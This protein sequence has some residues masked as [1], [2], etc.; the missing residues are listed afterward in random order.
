[1]FLRT[2]P[3]PSKQFF[4]LNWDEMHL[5]LRN[6]NLGF[7]EAMA[8]LCISLGTGSSHSVSKYSANFIEK[9]IGID[10]RK[11][12][13]A[14][15]NLLSYGH[16]KNESKN[17]HPKYV[18]KKTEN[19]IWLPFTIFYEF[20]RNGSMMQQL[21]KMRDIDLLEF[22]LLLYK[23][24]D[25]PNE[26]G[27]PRSIAHKQQDK[28]KLLKTLA[29]WDFYSIS[30]DSAATATMG[31]PLA[32]EFSKGR[33]IV[34]DEPFFKSTYWP[35]MNKCQDAGWIQEYYLLFEDD[36]L[37]SSFLYPVHGENDDWERKI[38][39]DA[40]R[41]VM[42]CEEKAQPL[43]KT[44]TDFVYQA[45]AGSFFVPID[46]N[47]TNATVFGV[48]RM[49]YRTQTEF[50]SAW[51]AKMYHSVDDQTYPMRK[52]IQETYG[53]YEELNPI[54]QVDEDFDDCPY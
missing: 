28:K 52:V 10:W 20:T 53:E 12:D 45:P 6:P 17:S 19:K 23:F 44:I 4:A 41:Y 35:L 33:N 26:G 13:N 34:L 43:S 14:I 22:V 16:L 31:N 18:L 27:I 25:L 49:R 40:Q 15:K 3:V 1:M 54:D 38:S 9:T 11:A 5:I 21:K 2:D 36:S 42:G 24:Q 50:T 39:T 46:K 37:E 32:L 7:N 30:C 48:Y 47:L 51:M 8:Y 29:K